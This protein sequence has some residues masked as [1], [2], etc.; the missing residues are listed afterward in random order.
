MLTAY[1][2]SLCHFI[3]LG[4]ITLVAACTPY[5]VPNDFNVYYIIAHD[6][7]EG[8]ILRLLLLF[9]SII[10][11]DSQFPLHYAYE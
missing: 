5:A 1:N 11:N 9:F 4:I 7:G 8:E 10:D 2:V 3:A 6:R